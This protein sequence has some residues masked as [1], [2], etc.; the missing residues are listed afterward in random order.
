MAD[1]LGL[2]LG[3]VGV[4]VDALTT[5]PNDYMAGERGV[6][7]HTPLRFTV[8]RTAPIFHFTSIYAFIFIFVLK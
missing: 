1:I 4:K 6:D 8:F 7:P 2:K 3:H 5:S